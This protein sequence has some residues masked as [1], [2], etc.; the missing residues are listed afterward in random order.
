MIAAVINDAEK[1]EADP[2][3]GPPARRV[4]HV[5][6]QAPGFP[7]RPRFVA[8]R[9]PDPLPVL[10]RPRFCGVSLP[11]T[12]GTCFSRGSCQMP[13]RAFWGRIILEAPGGKRKTTPSGSSFKKN[14][15]IQPPLPAL[16]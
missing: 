14:M 2:G 13:L 15:L 10:P 9:H 5:G 6:R 7:G 4:Q 12:G 11:F 1:V 8:F 3:G 16:L